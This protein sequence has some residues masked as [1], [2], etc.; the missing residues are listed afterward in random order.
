MQIKR[1]WLGQNWYLPG[2]E[3][4]DIHK[5]CLFSPFPRYPMLT[6]LQTNVPNIRLE[7]RRRTLEEEL[8]SIK[9]ASSSSSL[10]LGSTEGEK[11]GSLQVNGVGGAMVSSETIGAQAVAVASVQR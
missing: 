7:Y 2:A 10:P 11:S 6:Q 5:V 3:G 4:N 9:A 1:H 8:A